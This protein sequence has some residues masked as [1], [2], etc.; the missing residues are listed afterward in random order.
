MTSAELIEITMRTAGVALAATAVSLPLGI[1]LAFW[2]ARRDFAGK[3]FVQALVALPMVL[4]PTAVGLILLAAFSRENF[5]GRAIADT[6]GI[7]IVFTWKAAAIAAAVMAFPLLVRSI[8]QAFALV[9]RR[10]EQV[11]ESIGLGPWAVFFKITLPLSRRGLAYGCLLCFARALGEFGATSLIAGNIPGET[12]TL[13]LG[14]YSRIL[15][16]EDAEAFALMLV[17]LA[18]AIIAMWLGERYLRESAREARP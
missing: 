8:E 15:N 3:S 14:I 18:V 4:P 6:L 17:S 12:E 13:A 10:L 2:L 11:G 1:P 7:Q 9:P 16:G 5:I